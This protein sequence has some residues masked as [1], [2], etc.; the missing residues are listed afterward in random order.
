MKFS[1]IQILTR[2]RRLVPWIL[3]TLAICLFYDLTFFSHLPLPY[4]RTNNWETTTRPEILNTKTA[5]LSAI[6]LTT[7]RGPILLKF[8]PAPSAELGLVVV[9]GIGKDAGT[10]TNFDS[11]AEGLYDRLGK[12][13]ISE[14]VSTVHLGFRRLDPF[15]DTVHDVRAAIA[16]LKRQGLSRIVLVGHSL[17][18]ASCICAASYEPAVV[19]VVALCSQPYG[20]DRVSTL[21]QRRL[22]VGTGLLDIVEPPCWSSAIYREARCTKELKYFPAFHDL[23]TCADDVYTWLNQWILTCKNKHL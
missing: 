20:A 21:Q 12:A 10:D 13:L 3:L 18:G 14:Q 4:C 15:E 8:Y 7:G 6:A 19:G 11:P 2:P 17:G 16:F 9:G 22:L 1:K 5:N 23:N